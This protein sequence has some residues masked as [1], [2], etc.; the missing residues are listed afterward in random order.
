MCVGRRERYHSSIS[1]EWQRGTKRKLFWIPKTISMT[2]G[3]LKCQIAA[4]AAERGE[5][6]ELRRGEGAAHSPA[7]L[8]CGT[9]LT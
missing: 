3:A 5:V 9:N 6:K 2:I 1:A 7:P 8:T 4:A